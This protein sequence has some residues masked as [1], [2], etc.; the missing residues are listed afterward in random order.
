MGHGTPYR[1]SG[2]EDPTNARNGLT[3]PETALFKEPFVVGVELLEG[4]VRKDGSARYLGD[5]QHE[6]VTASDGTCRRSEQF[7]VQDGFFILFTLGRIDPVRK[8]C[9]NNDYDLSEVEL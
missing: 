4:I 2:Y 1:S 5:L 8:G 9:I 6:C 3:S 7:P